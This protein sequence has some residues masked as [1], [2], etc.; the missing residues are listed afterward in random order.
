MFVTTVLF[1]V[2]VT[3]AY[4]VF[5]LLQPIVFGVLVTI[6]YIVVICSCY[7]SLLF[8][9]LVTTVYIVIYFLM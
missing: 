4:L 5:L 3:K 1:S 2:F 6:G 9:V 7:Y 8:I